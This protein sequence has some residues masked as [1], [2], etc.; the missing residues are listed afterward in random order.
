MLY[1]LH[2]G[3]EAGVGG[4]E[5]IHLVT[6]G[7]GAGAA[8]TATSAYWLMMPSAGSWSRPSP[9][10]FITVS[11]PGMTVC[12]FAAAVPAPAPA[13]YAYA[14]VGLFV[15]P[16]FPT[17]L[18]WLLEVAPQARR[19]SALVIAASMVGGVAAGPALGKVVERAGI[20]AVPLLLAAVS[21]L[22]LAATLRLISATRTS[23]DPASEAEGLARR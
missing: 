22:C 1:V 18:P 13:P 6:V 10:A 20:R 23:T 21:L 9:Q 2:V 12:L 17:A 15:A 14:G 16:I 3:I 5:P 19:A 4:W 7:Y 8:A 11:C